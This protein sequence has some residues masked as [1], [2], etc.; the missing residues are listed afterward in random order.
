MHRCKC[1]A[2]TGPDDIIVG[3]S[4]ILRSTPMPFSMYLVYFFYINE[5][6]KEALAALIAIKPG[7]EVICI[8]FDVHR[9]VFPMFLTF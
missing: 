9:Q 6:T 5:N 2:I 8:I 1:D 7:T 4:Y 3:I